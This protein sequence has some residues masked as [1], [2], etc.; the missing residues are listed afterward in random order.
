MAR[1]RKNLT[2]PFAMD[3]LAAG[4]GASVPTFRRRW[5]AVVKTPPARY[6]QELRMQEASRMLVETR[7]P[8]KQTARD[9]GYDDGFYFSRRFRAQTGMP[10]SDCRRP[11]LLD[12]ARG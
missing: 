1:L 11:F 9:V 7:L 12:P 8:V 6:L 4:L 5:L 10:P 3:F 2:K